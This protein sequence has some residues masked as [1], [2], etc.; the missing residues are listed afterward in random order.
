MDFRDLR[1]TKKGEYAEEIIDNFLIRKGFIVCKPV[2]DNKSHYIDRVIYRKKNKKELIW[3]DVKCKS[4]RKYYPDTGFDY[5]DYEK[6]KDIVT[7]GSKVV[8]FFV[9][10]ETQSVYGGLLTDLEKPKKVGKKN[11]P[12]IEYCNVKVIYFPL[13]NMQT[14]F[15]FSDFDSV[16]LKK[17]T[18][19]NY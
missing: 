13:E 3:V 12:L 18:D 1:T 14:F 16:E 11:Y 5:A 10:E 2:E 17:L 9:N 19:S 7:S 6:Y 4:S 15:K 8:L